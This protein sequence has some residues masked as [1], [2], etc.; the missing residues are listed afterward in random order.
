MAAEFDPDRVALLIEALNPARL[1]RIV[2]VGANPITDVPYKG[3]LDLGG[4]EVWGFEPQPDAYANLTR[5][6]RPREHYLPYAVGSGEEA[7]LRIC[8]SS[9]LSSLLQP[10]RQTFDALGHFHRQGTVLS[11]AQVRTHRLDDMSEIPDFDLLKI[12]VQGSELAVFRGA[13]DKLGRAV[14]IVTEVAAVPLYIDQPLLDT[15]MTHLRELGY[16]LHKFLF[17]KSV[18]VRSTATARLVDRRHS[19]QLVDGDAVF[20]RQLLDLSALDIE[21]LKHLAV[22]ADAV[23]GSHDLAAVILGRLVDSGHASRAALES[24]IDRLPFA[25][26]VEEAVS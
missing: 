10:N 12:D 17:F 23:F 2:D 9:G 11:E 20:V 4:C 15:Q 13:A 22:L 5:T 8:K 19:S 3:L 21:A 16:H 18:K 24:Y 7:T 1:T 26:R 14:A 6:G 25:A